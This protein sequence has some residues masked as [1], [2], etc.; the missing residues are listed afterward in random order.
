VSSSRYVSTCC[1]S[2]LP[3]L[4]LMW[5]GHAGATTGDHLGVYHPAARPPPSSIRT[6]V[7][8]AV[9]VVVGNASDILMDH[10][11]EC[12]CSRIFLEAWHLADAE[13]HVLWKV[14]LVGNYTYDGL[15]PRKYMP[16]CTGFPRGM[17]SRRF[18]S[19]AFCAR[20]DLDT[21]IIHCTIR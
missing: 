8:V 10:T 19:I 18:N 14:N 1:A 4:D 2:V 3:L 13:R 21:I 7:A 11:T 15:A 9:D 17:P 20:H 16:S 5:T 6:H 12:Q